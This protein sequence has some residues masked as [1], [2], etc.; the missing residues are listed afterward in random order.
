M[1]VDFTHSIKQSILFTQGG[2][3]GSGRVVTPRYLAAPMDTYFQ[4]LSHAG[5]VVPLHSCCPGGASS[6]EGPAVPFLPAALQDAGLGA[7]G[8]LL[9]LLS[10]TSV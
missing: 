9:N 2:G 7:V 10:Q 4:S 6:H 5:S 3:L 8:A 1:I